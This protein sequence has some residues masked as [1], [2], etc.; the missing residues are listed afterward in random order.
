MRSTLSAASL[1]TSPE[2]LTMRY[3]LGS[4]RYSWPKILEPNSPSPP[5]ILKPLTAILCPD[6]P[7]RTLCPVRA[8][9]AYRKHRG[10]IRGNLRRL[11]LSWNNNYRK[12]ICKSTISKRL[13]RAVVFTAW[14]SFSRRWFTKR[15]ILCAIL[16]KAT[17]SGWALAGRDL[18]AQTD[19]SPR[20]SY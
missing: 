16:L 8:L 10:P 13:T 17:L 6:D 7:E 5:I 15:R 19:N 12:D 18:G 2:S 14:D 11:I 4:C 9:R 3:P 1:V 20:V